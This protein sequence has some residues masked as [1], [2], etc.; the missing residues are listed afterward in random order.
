MSNLPFLQC[1]KGYH[2]IFQLNIQVPLFYF[3]YQQNFL[4]THKYKQQNYFINNYHTLF[5][6]W[7]RL[8]SCACNSIPLMVCVCLMN[9]HSILYRSLSS[10]PPLMYSLFPSL[11]IF[12]SLSSVPNILESCIVSP[13]NEYNKPET[14]NYKSSRIGLAE[15]LTTF[16]V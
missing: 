14:H 10:F 3:F 13:N 6:C 12:P 4:R 8:S 11:S 15:K 16:P 9:V 5:Y 1:L 2:V 7:V